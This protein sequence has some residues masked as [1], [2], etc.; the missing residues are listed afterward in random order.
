[1]THGAVPGR[2]RRRDSAIT[3]HQTNGRFS[4]QFSSAGPTGIRPE[5]TLTLHLSHSEN[6]GCGRRRRAPGDP[7]EETQAM[8]TGRVKTNGNLA[9]WSPRERTT[10]ALHPASGGTRS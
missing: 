3:T 4:D 10:A 9:S 7:D 2:S 1:M 6:R 5:R 8:I